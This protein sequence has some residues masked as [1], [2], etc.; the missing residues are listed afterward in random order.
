MGLVSS[1]RLLTEER[2][3]PALTT[4]FLFARWFST[5][6]IEHK[7]QP[8]VLEL[9]RRPGDELASVDVI[10]IT[11]KPMGGSHSNICFSVDDQQARFGTAV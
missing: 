4:V 11:V 10:V 7:R 8:S 5:I 6:W 2:N 1:C 9:A 3:L